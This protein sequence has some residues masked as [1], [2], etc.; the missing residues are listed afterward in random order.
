MGPRRALP[1]CGSLPA[2]GG[3]G[4]RQTGGGSSVA[5]AET[6]L[7]LPVLASTIRE[8]DRMAPA[9]GPGEDKAGGPLGAALRLLRSQP[10][11]RGSFRLGSF[12]PR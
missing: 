8:N 5:L 6:R 10:L 9:A 11:S 12:G 4:L 3:V 7:P 2:A 1:S